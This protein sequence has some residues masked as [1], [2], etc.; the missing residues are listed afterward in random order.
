M[1]KSW[2]TLPLA[3]DDEI[4][5]VEELEFKDECDII[6]FYYDENINRLSVYE[7]VDKFNVDYKISEY[8][9]QLMDLAIECFD[10]FIV[11]EAPTHIFDVGI[12][13]N[14]VAKFVE[15]VYYNSNK[16]RNL[17]IILQIQ[18]EYDE[19][20]EIERIKE[21]VLKKKLRLNFGF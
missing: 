5:E 14:R 8:R 21:E 10:K 20:L 6:N 9:E 1:S 3:Y 18:N 12:Y 11:D 4:E 16:G 13:N 2:E 19:K 15:F 17:E 7:A